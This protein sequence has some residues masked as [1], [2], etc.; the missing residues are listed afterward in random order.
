MNTW[1]CI[2]VNTLLAD[3]GKMNGISNMNNKELCKKMLWMAF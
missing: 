2:N 1:V 3:P